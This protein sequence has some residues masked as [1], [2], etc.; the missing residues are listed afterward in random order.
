MKDG[1]CINVKKGFK[2]ICKAC[3]WEKQ[4]KN[5]RKNLLAVQEIPGIGMCSVLRD[6]PQ[7]EQ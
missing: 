4:L 2:L 6:D 5:R 7:V 3:C 1:A